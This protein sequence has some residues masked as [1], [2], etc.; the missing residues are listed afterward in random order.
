MN[1]A[2]RIVKYAFFAIVGMVVGHAV[3]AFHGGSIM[4][5]G[6]KEFSD[7]KMALYFSQKGYS[8]P[9]AALNSPEVRQLAAQYFEVKT[10]L[11]LSGAAVFMLFARL[12]EQRH[13]GKSKEE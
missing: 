7:A 8:T 12:L 9:D 10:Y 5:I 1:I 3:A 6:E 13:K 2:G 11:K 4:G